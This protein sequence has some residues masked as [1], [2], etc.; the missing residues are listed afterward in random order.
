[1]AGINLLGLNN[2]LYSS[3]LQLKLRLLEMAVT[4]VLSDLREASTL[5]SPTTP[6]LV[7]R[8]ENAQ[9]L[10]RWVY[11]LAVLDPNSD[12]SKKMSVKV[13]RG[14]AQT[15]VPLTSLTSHNL[16]VP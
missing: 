14:T 3:H 15:N 11:D 12:S 8:I 13:S 9:Q 6:S 1:M 4:A 7:N 5:S 10:I 16:L 2:E